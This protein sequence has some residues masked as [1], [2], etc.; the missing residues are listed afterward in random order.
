MTL[1]VIVLL[2][3]NSFLKWFRRRWELRIVSINLRRVVSIALWPVELLSVE[4]LSSLLMS[5]T[6][7]KELGV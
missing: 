3:G 7:L 4:L 1:L 2:L 5:S 6:R